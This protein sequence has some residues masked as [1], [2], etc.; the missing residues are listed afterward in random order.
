VQ[1]EVKGLHH[2]DTKNT[3]FHQERQSVSLFYLVLLGVLGALVVR[4]LK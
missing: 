2:Q 1:D 4:F 3:K